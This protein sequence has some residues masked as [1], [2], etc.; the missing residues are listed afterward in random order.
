MGGGGGSNGGHQKVTSSDIPNL[1]SPKEVLWG[2]F[3]EFSRR[4]GSRLARDDSVGRSDTDSEHSTTA[5]GSPGTTPT[6]SYLLQEYERRRKRSQRRK[7][8]KSIEEVPEAEKG[9]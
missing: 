4:V 3:E 2:H 6:G 8:G 7:R 5:S 9:D 1:T